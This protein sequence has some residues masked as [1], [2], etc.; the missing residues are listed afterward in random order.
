MAV[1]HRRRGGG[2][3]QTKGSIVGRNKIYGWKILSGHFWCTKFWVP[4]PPPPSNASLG[5]GGGSSS[6]RPPPPV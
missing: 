1:H 4:D 2:G 6:Q 5:G 3:G